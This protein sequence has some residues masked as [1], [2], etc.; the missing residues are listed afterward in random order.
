M[1]SPHHLSLCIGSQFIAGRGQ[2]IEA[3][4]VTK[5]KYNE[6]SIIIIFIRDEGPWSVSNNSQ[7]KAN[8]HHPPRP[9]PSIVC[10]LWHM[11]ACHVKVCDRLCR[12]KE[13]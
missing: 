13:R 11:V 9:P 12:M 6:H 7:P 2:I 3:L 5:P 8:R 4:L 10:F 1:D